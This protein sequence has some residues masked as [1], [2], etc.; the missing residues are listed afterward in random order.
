M[1]FDA[2][3][4]TPREFEVA[5]ENGLWTIPSKDGYPADATEQMAEAANC[6]IDREIL[7]GRKYFTD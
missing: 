5:E 6:L 2:E 4:A 7:R 1:K 3:T